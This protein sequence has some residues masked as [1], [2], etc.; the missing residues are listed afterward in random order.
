MKKYWTVSINVRRK[1]AKTQSVY[2][3]ISKYVCWYSPWHCSCWLLSLTIICSCNLKQLGRRTWLTRTW[4]LGWSKSSW[5]FC[6]ATSLECLDFTLGFTMFHGWS[7]RWCSGGSILILVA[8]SLLASVRFVPGILQRQKELGRN[9]ARLDM[10]GYP[11]AW[12][13][14]KSKS[15]PCHTTCSATCSD[16]RST[17]K[18]AGPDPGQRALSQPSFVA[19]AAQLRTVETTEA[20]AYGSTFLP[21]VVMYS[22][23]QHVQ[24]HDHVEDSCTLIVM[25]EL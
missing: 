24:N 15:A 10:S 25:A 23:I 4:Q 20:G 16:R 22:M 19:T 21:Y 9:P 2:P 5:G 14:W 8:G 12:H 1:S 7:I 3:N 11:E 13:R 18:K 17:S 6:E